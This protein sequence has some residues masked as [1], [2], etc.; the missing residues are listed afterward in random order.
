[1]LLLCVPIFHQTVEDSAERFAIDEAVE[2]IQFEDYPLDD[3][4][5]EADDAGVAA[6]PIT[7]NIY[8]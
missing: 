7:D 4:D 5:A 1:V 3:G 2:T 6:M 8:S